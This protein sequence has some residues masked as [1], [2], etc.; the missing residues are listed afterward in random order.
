MPYQ[1]ETNPYQ[2][3]QVPAE[4]HAENLATTETSKAADWAVSSFGAGIVGV[5]LLCIFPPASLVLSIVAVC[6]GRASLR[7][8]YAGDNR[9]GGRDIATAGLAIGS[10][11][12]IGFV[13]MLFAM[14]AGPAL[15]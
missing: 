5:C 9:L 10:F 2:P 3:P 14:L 12:M 6:Y 11:L 13:V 7:R 4:P 1:L 8:F 15:Y